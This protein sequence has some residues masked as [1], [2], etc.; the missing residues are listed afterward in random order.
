MNIDLES[1][2]MVIDE[3]QTEDTNEMDEEIAPAPTTSAEAMPVDE[4]VAEVQATTMVKSQRKSIRSFFFPI[5]SNR[6]QKNQVKPFQLRMCLW[7]RL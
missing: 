3:K 5:Q 1:P 2:S 6:K 4:S 7:K